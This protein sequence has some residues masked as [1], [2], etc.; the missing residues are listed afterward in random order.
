MYPNRIIDAGM[1]GIAGPIIKG[2]V[3]MVN[4]NW[5]EIEI[6]DNTIQ[7]KFANKLE[8]INDFVAQC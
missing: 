6:D 8:I 3:K 5:P 4:S 7:S 1:I 2:K